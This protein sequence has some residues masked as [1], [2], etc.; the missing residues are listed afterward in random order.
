[1]LLM[2]ETIESKKIQIATQITIPAGSTTGTITL[3]ELKT[4]NM[5]RKW[6]LIVTSGSPTNATTSSTEITIQ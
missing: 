4:L 5:R 2:L 6:N 3:L 1:M